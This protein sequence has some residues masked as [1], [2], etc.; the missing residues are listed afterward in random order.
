M[1]ILDEV[2]GFEFEEV[3]CSVFRNLG[4]EDVEK[5]RKTADK[6]RDITMI[7]S[8]SR[9]KD[10][11][12]VVECKHTDTVGRPVVQKLDSAVSTYSHDGPKRGMIATTGRLTN[13]AIEYAEQ[14]GIEIFDGQRIREVA[15]EVG[16]DLYNG[17]V[18]IITDSVLHP[19]RPQHV[20]DE[21]YAVIDRIKY[22]SRDEVPDPLT[23][24]SLHPVIAADT[25]TNRVFETG[26]GVIHT[27]D[28]TDNIVVDGMSSELDGLTDDLDTIV[29][30]Y[31]L[32]TDVKVIDEA[33]YTQVAD[34]ID[35]R[36]FGGTDQEFR[37]WIK[38]QER[39]RLTETVSYTGDNNQTYSK[40][41]AP[42][43]DDVTIRLLRPFY[44]CRIDA[45]MKLNKR[46]YA[47]D[48]FATADDSWVV[49]NTI[50]TCRFAEEGRGS[51]DSVP[52]AAT[53]LKEAIGDPTYAFCPLCETIVAERYMRH[54]GVTGEPVCVEC[55]VTDRFVGAKKHF[56]SDDTRQQYED[57]VAAK[58][59]VEKLSVNKTGVITVLAVLLVFALLFL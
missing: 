20:L 55:A 43:L 44:V 54:D 2:D 35:R 47:L 8:A 58:G 16:M 46:T 17:R 9:G 21:F 53:A 31:D 19:P 33:E 7:D 3:M 25:K 5:S 12:V 1:P 59:T 50:E 23:T 56:R 52:A 15:D 57:E 14:V 32:D 13:P 18:E 29:S 27:I 39:D 24:I 22:L 11:A 34:R 26:A 41:C 4:Y 48:W 38:Q 42:S 49:D 28:E 45:S 51:I 6:G 36:R 40:E 37:R 30:A 10:E